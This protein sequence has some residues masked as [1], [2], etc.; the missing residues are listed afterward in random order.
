MPEM[1]VDNNIAVVHGRHWYFYIDDFDTY[2]ALTQRR[3]GKTSK[4]N[5]RTG[6]EKKDE[7]EWQQYDRNSVVQLSSAQHRS[8]QLKMSKWNKANLIKIDFCR[9]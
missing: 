4:K 8:A 3:K 6:H 2:N 1:H 7:G 5:K 9:D